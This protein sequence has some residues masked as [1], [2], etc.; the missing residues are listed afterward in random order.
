MKRASVLS[1]V[2]ALGIATALG[3][4]PAPAAAAVTP[5]AGA[6]SAKQAA[7]GKTLYGDNCSSCHGVDLRGVAGPALTGDAFTSQWTNEPVSDM[8][9]LM[10]KNMPLGAPGSLKPSEYLAITAYLLQQSK[11]P[12][13]A[14]PL[15]IAKLKTVRLF[16]RAE[17]VGAS[18]EP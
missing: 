15:T 7:A 1:A 17:E 2:A 14:T 13:G 16:R 5:S 8:Y 6:Y 10:S 18:K 4:S 3:L 9:G 11:Y 12:A